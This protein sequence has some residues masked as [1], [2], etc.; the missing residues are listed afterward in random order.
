MTF[1]LDARFNEDVVIDRINYDLAN[2]LGNL[3]NRTFN[4]TGKFFEGRIPEFG[5]LNPGRDEMLASF[6]KAAVAYIEHSSKFQTSVG[7]EKLWEFIRSLN[8]YVDE[9]KPWQ[10]AKEGKTEELASVMRNLLEAI[11]SV[12]VLLSPI[13]ITISPKIAA[14]LN[15]SDISRDVKTLAGLKNLKAG[16][17]IGDPG[18]LFPKMRN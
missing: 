9:H 12:A 15:M 4:M 17:E 13:L 18:I 2:D 5:E 3:V 6:E 1:G 16:T 7:I 14:A 11:Y 8:K 10:L